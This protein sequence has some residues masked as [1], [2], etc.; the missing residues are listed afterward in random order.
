MLETLDLGGKW[1]LAQAGTNRVLPACVPGTVHTDL[2]SAGVIDDPYYRDNENDLQWIGERN[3]TYTRTFQVSSEMLD[4]DKIV[5][6]CDGLDTLATITVNNKRLAS[7]YNMFR[8]YEFDLAGMLN[9][10]KNTISVKFDS[11]IPYT[12]KQNK[13]R[14]VFDWIMPR[15][16]SLPRLWLVCSKMQEPAE[17]ICT[18]RAT[19]WTRIPES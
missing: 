14:Q 10:G 6:R 4:R 16:N 9:K 19:A 3:W 17:W 7:T 5:L 12:N 2:L 1:S 15:R 8:T 18:S 11:V 13:K